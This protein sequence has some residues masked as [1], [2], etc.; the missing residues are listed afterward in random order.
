MTNT[1]A[2]TNNQKAILWDNLL[3]KK[4]EREKERYQRNIQQRLLVKT[5]NNFRRSFSSKTISHHSGFLSNFV[6][7][8]TKT[9]A[10]SNKINLKKWKKPLQA[11]LTV[12]ARPLFNVTKGTTGRRLH[13][14]E[15][16]KCRN[17]IISF[18]SVNKK[19]TDGGSWIDLFEVKK[20]KLP[21]ANMGLFAMQSF[22]AG[23]TLG[24]YYGKLLPY[25]SSDYSCY[26][27]K[28]DI[29]NIIMDCGGGIDSNHPV[30]FGL[31]FANDP[32]LCKTIKTRSDDRLYAHN[33]FVDE[34]FIARASDDIIEGQELFLYYGWNTEEIDN[35]N[36]SDPISPSQ[37]RLQTDNSCHC[38][39]CSNRI[40]NFSVAPADI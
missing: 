36:A 12:F 4:R 14:R 19:M 38:S 17:Y 5:T 26:A 27:M 32:V 9:T 30:Y 1:T 13:G 39:G 22:K 11:Q 7:K 15:I 24:V 28:S 3:L 25:D 35:H 16:E 37:Q 21:G 23:D 8:L 10:K 40:K 33:I 18:F 20:S 34:N 31:Q 6:T 2:T 29:H